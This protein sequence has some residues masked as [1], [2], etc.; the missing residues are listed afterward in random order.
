MTD[1][2]G[3]EA[4]RLTFGIK[5]RDGFNLPEPGQTS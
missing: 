3:S 2:K 4:A 5:T 1:P